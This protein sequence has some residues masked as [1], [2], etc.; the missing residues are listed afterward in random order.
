MQDMETF[1]KKNG[2]DRLVMVWCGSTEIFMKT[3][4][5]HADPRRLREGPAR[6]PPGHPPAA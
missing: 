4:E 1:K 3:A 6:G 2:C 5:V